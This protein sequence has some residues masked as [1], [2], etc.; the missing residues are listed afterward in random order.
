MLATFNLF[1]QV[2]VEESRSMLFTSHMWARVNE[3]ISISLFSSFG[4]CLRVLLQEF[5]KMNSSC[6]FTENSALSPVLLPNLVGCFFMGFIQPSGKVNNLEKVLGKETLTGISTGFN[7]SLTSFSSWAYHS[8][9]L[10]FVYYPSYPEIME[11]L[12]CLIIGF[13]VSYF[14]F[15]VGVDFGVI[16]NRLYSKCG[17]YQQLE[18]SILLSTESHNIV[19]HFSVMLCSRNIF[20]ICY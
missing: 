12:W 17:R 4:C 6:S 7:G 13:C 20:S 11:F 1:F 2:L 3:I 5:S 14:G 15:C 10:L 9:F 16:A 8:T 19:S 18:D